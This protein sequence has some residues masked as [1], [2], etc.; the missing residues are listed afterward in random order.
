MNTRIIQCIYTIFDLYSQI[1]ANRC[2]RIAAYHLFLVDG[3]LMFSVSFRSMI[4]GHLTLKNLWKEAQDVNWPK[5]RR[6]FR[7]GALFPWFYMCTLFQRF[8]KTSCAKKELKSLTSSP[9]TGSVFTITL[10]VSKAYHLNL[11]FTAVV[12]SECHVLVASALM[13]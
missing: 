5:L 7:H 3:N 10:G 11:T 6:I 12:R 2:R 9:M 1:Q 4:A 13:G 8:E